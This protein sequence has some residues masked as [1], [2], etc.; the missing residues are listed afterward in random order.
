MMHSTPEVTERLAGTDTGSVGFV[1]RHGL[2]TDEQ[3][4]RAAELEPLLAELEFVRVGFG[5]PHGLFRS[6]TLTVEAFRTALRN[7][8]DFS[9]GPFVFDTG[10]AVAVDIFA[11]GGGIG[12]PEL[13]G[14]GDFLVVPD[15]LTFRELP[16]TEARTGWVVADEYLRDGRPHPLSSRAVLRRTLDRAAADGWTFVVG[17]E[18]E[19]YLTRSAGE[20]RPGRI[21]GFGVQGAAPEV[22]PV[23]DGYQFN[24]DGLTDAL[25][26][27]LTPLTR[28]LRAL[29]LPLRSVEHESGPGQVEFTFSPMEGLAA[30]D[31]MLLLRTVTKQICARAGYHASFMALP[32]LDGFDPSGWHLHQSLFRAEGSGGTGGNAF[33]AADGAGP[34]S[35]TGLA[36]VGGLLEHARDVSA[37]CVP[38][39]NGYRRLAERHTLS[40]DR[41]VWSPE[42]RGAMVRVL[43]APGE[44]STHV[45]NRIGEP[46]ANPYLYLAAQL[47]A[48][49]D[50]IERGLRPGAPA[51]DPHA[52]ADS[53]L[54]ADLE[55]AV[56]ALEG[57]AL[58]RELLGAPLTECL[59]R[60]KRSEHTR[61]T[62]WLAKAGPVEPGVATDW[63]HREYFGAF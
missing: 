50:G 49:L 36:Y 26:P 52:P 20:R 28:A 61:F 23:D 35:R 32:G 44:P 33:M 34:L 13:S 54:P 30:A 46:C 56:R 55:E 16:Y 3:H 63:E 5:D 11:P 25:M 60:L 58:C 57:S 22:E 6:K 43:G 12:V 27:V 59:V 21:G 48:G 2:W 41:I 51:T 42:N 53:A 38:T 1:G 31:A 40:P 8:M 37:L 4:A 39:V 47:A 15:P 17:L 18:V 29:G 19:W 45:E 62:D 14:A 24:H 9:P 7:G 10:H